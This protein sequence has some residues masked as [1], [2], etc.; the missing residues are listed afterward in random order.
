VSREEAELFRLGLAQSRLI[1][2]RQRGRA[3][4]A[5]RRAV[6]KARTA[7]WK[8]P[9]DAAVRARREL[10]ALRT[11]AAL[12]EPLPVPPARLVEDLP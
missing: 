8:A 10:S 3:D 12:H 2:A 7:A 9:I 4:A 5:E 11:A 1:E 6:A